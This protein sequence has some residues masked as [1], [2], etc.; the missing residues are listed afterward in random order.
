MNN[1]NEVTPDFWVIYPVSLRRDN[2]SSKDFYNE[3]KLALV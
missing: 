1:E 3:D 2:F